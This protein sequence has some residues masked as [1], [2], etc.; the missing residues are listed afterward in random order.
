M[1][2]RLLIRLPALVALT[3]LAV[4]AMLVLFPSARRFY[5]DLFA[6]GWCLVLAIIVLLF[7]DAAFVF[8]R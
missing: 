5:F 8:R 3:L 4:G 6:G 2:R 1:D 7:R